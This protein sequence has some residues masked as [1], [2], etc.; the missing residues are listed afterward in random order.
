MR[1]R[2][3]EAKKTPSTFDFPR[4]TMVRCGGAPKFLDPNCSNAF[5]LRKLEHTL[6][7]KEIVSYYHICIFGCLWYGPGSVG[8]FLD[9]IVCPAENIYKTH[10]VALI[11]LAH[12]PCHVTKPNKHKAPKRVGPFACKKT[13]KTSLAFFQKHFFWINKIQH[14]L[15]TENTWTYGIPLSQSFNQLVQHLS[16]DH[17]AKMPLHRSR[18]VLLLSCFPVSTVAAAVHESFYC[19][20][21]VLSRKIASNAIIQN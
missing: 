2:Q 9:S 16:I 6:F 11:E 13:L 21:V 4:P 14:K 1:V 18:L 8:F 17:M 15:K 7:M 3:H 19:S 20:I 5:H 12:S 10:C